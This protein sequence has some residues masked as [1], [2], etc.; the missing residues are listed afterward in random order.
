MTYRSPCSTIVCVVFAFV[1]A[2]A[3]GTKQLP[4]ADSDSP[5]TDSASSEIVSTRSPLEFGING[6]YRLGHMTTVRVTGSAAETAL[7]ESSNDLVLETLD[8]DGV[9]VRY[10]SHGLPKHSGTAAPTRNALEVGLIIAGSEAA[11][12]E[13]RRTVDGQFDSIAKGRLPEAG[14]PARGPAF[15]P[16]DTPWV[17][18]IGDAFGIDE[19]G[20]SNVLTDKLARIAVSKIQSAETLP[21]H[22]LGYDGVN[23]VIINRAGLDVIEAMDDR[24]ADALVGWIRNGGHCLISMGE[25]S[26]RL[27]AAAPWLLELLPF[28]SVELNR[29]D[30]AALETFTTSQTPLDVFQGIKLPRRLGKPIL[31]GR[32]TRR[33]SAVLIA[34][35]VNGLGK[36]TVVAA[37]LDQP[38]FAEWPERLSLVTQSLGELL[39]EENSLNAAGDG[40]TTF[41]DLAGQMRGV[42]DQFQIK[43]QFDFSVISLIVLILIAAIGPLDFLLI[44]RVLGKPLLGWVSF[45]IFAIA[46]SAFLVTQARPRTELSLDNSDLPEG[47]NSAMHLVRTNQF[48]ITDLDL[49]DGVGRAFRWSAI[50]AHDP[51]QADVLV[52]PSD[53]LASMVAPNASNAGYSV[54]YPFGYPGRVFGGI[55]L[56]G[57]S[58]RLL[59]YDIT[60]NGSQSQNAGE[61]TG[62]TSTISNLTIAPRSSKSI[63]T[64]KYF[65]AD[66]SKGQEIIRRPGSDLLRGDFVNPLPVD[67]LDAILIYQNT[68]YLLPT[69]VQA[70]A[71]LASI[72]NVRQRNFR[73]RLTRKVSSEGS[74]TESTPWLANDFSDISRVADMLLFHD[75]AGGK[76]YTGLRHDIL[77][78]LDLSEVLSENRCILIGRTEEPLVQM[79]MADQSSGAESEPYSVS[80]EKSLSMVRVVLP[81]RSTLLTP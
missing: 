34:E 22:Q 47:G 39:A 48:Q 18:A 33:V 32:T 16:P 46:L 54:S 26:E 74:G 49:V 69:R 61:F 56:A 40:A 5:A 57:E 65:A 35:Y 2:I 70:N 73:W 80:T 28:E 24:Q 20:T 38:M 75:A 50:Y 23:L 31:L 53:A 25:A 7:S 29:Y 77:D 27:A 44:N 4:A 3:F 6:H 42:L 43:K 55:Q 78:E 60:A 79:Q 19:L 72:E 81:V 41:N 58:D 36:L 66:P 76:L 14:N 63:A 45:P 9:R 30:P 13:V 52:K 8:G 59:P 12:V 11:P 67:L 64:Q 15:I 37:D 68:A 62:S 51:I 21:H 1:S 10:H 17:V 71:T